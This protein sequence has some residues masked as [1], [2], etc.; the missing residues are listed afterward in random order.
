[1]GGKS[2]QEAFSENLFNSH[3]VCVCVHGKDRSCSEHIEST[4]PSEFCVS[5]FG[6]NE[7]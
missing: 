6:G 1:M 5:S 4:V 7:I 3:G 2:W